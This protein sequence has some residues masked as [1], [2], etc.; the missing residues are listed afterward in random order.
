LDSGD[1]DLV[2]GDRDTEDTHDANAVKQTIHAKSVGVAK[3]TPV[4]RYDPLSAVDKS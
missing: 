2:C 3:F 1:N 4:G